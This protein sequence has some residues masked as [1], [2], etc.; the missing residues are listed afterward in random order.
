MTT[1]VYM[2]GQ[3]EEKTMAFV[4]PESMKLEDVPTPSN[5]EVTVRQIEAGHFGVYKFS[6]VRT[7]QLEADST[8]KVKVWLQQLSEKFDTHQTPLFGYFDPPWTP[9]FAR[10]NEVMIRLMRK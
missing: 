1:P 7:D 8:N 10:R 3:A 4:M 2:Q 6:G 9:G 5:A